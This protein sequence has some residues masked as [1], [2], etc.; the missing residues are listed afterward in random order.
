M[1]YINISLLHPHE[2]INIEKLEIIIDIIKL[3]NN[4]VFRPIIVDSSSLV[5]LDWHH[6]LYAAKKLWINKI[7]VILIDYYS[8]NIILEADNLIT[9][10][11]VIETAL[12]WKL[13]L[14]KSTFHYIIKDWNK[15][16]ISEVFY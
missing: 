5:V 13:L 11:Y 4:I 7:P 8:N 9:K 12:N 3:N 14:A 16:H 1:K 6:R 2:H 10:K 15:L